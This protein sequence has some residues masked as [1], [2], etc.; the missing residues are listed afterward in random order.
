LTY[1]TKELEKGWF[2][3]VVNDRKISINMVDYSESLSGT[4]KT[5][6]LNF[7]ND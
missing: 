3:K 6:T 2:R 4:I 5:G 1:I 7:E